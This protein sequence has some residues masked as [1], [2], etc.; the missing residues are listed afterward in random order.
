MIHD[1]MRA[2][3]LSYQIRPTQQNGNYEALKNEAIAN[4]V[5]DVIICGGDGTVN[6]IAAYFQ[7]TDI[8][9]GIIPMGSG[10]GLALA[11]GIPL[12][13]TKALSLIL[14]GSTKC[15]DAFTVNGRFACMLSGIGLDA[16]IAHDFSK[17]KKRGL[18]TY[19]RVSMAAFFRTGTYPVA[20]SGDGINLQSDIWFV[21]IANS[22]QF[23]NR[24][25]IAPQ[26][27]L[28]DGLL[29]VVVVRKKNRFST[30]F[31]LL[32]QILAGKVKQERN[33]LNKA[34]AIWY[35]QCSSLVINNPALAPLHLDGEPISTAEKID[36]Q[37]IP[38]ALQLIQ[39]V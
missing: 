22:N 36:I 3:R 16:Q 2:Q 20:L 15:I 30:A 27:R 28:Q 29:D 10:N 34:Q 17:Q 23:G 11:A 19:V 4:G 39:P 14:T 18:L 13:I 37:V 7:Y 38:G 32:L 25:T 1:T 9:L 5:T 6:E 35:F 21:S 33:E 26:A 12:S 8:H 31:S 24:V